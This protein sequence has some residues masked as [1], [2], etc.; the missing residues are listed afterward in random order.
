MQFPTPSITQTTRERIL[1]PFIQGFTTEGIQVAT[2]DRAFAGPNLSK[3]FRSQRKL[4]SRDRKIVSEV[5]YTLIRFEQWFV[6]TGL[7]NE[8]LHPES[9][10]TS[11][12]DWIHQPVEFE[13]L[14]LAS[15]LSIPKWMAE[16]FSNISDIDKF[17]QHHQQ[18]A[19]IDLRCN[20]QNTT[21]KKVQTAL[22]RGNIPCQP[23]PNTEHGLRIEGT[24]NIQGDAL[25]TQGKFE[26]QDAASQYFIERLRSH[27]TRGTS[28]LDYCAGAGG[29]SLALAALGAKVY[30]NEPRSHALDEL[31]KRAKRANIQIR[32]GLPKNKV[33]IVV[34]D[35]PCSGTGRLRREPTVRWKW[36]AKPPLDWAPIQQE[37]LTEAAQYVKDDGIIAYATCSILPQENCHTLEGWT[38]ERHTI[39]GHER[40]CD[41]FSWS[42]FKRSTQ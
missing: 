18:R 16:S 24:A 32:T 39:Y 25:Y 12:F 35:A 9:D 37:I 28:I 7:L 22:Q 4:G 15:H 33:D 17:A 26:V 36:E 11:V 23:I 41:G 19:P 20:A 31:K 13:Q 40:N 5:V 8:P 14:D 10:L 27:I 3:W 34:V 42:I 29:K 1:R 21:R 38:A 30:A 2:K 6:R